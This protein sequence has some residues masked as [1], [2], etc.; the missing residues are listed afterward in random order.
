MYY[1]EVSMTWFIIRIYPSKESL[2]VFHKF[3][4][5]VIEIRIFLLISSRAIWDPNEKPR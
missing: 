4:A 1:I 3:N 2:F 5:F